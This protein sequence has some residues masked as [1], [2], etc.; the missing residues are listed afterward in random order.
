VD[1]EWEI[2]ACYKSGTLRIG[3]ASLSRI[4]KGAVL[5]VSDED[6]NTLAEPDPRIVRAFS[7]YEL[8]ARWVR[9]SEPLKTSNQ[10]DQFKHLEEKDPYSHKTRNNRVDGGI[11]EIRAALFPE[12]IHNWRRL[13]YGWIFACS[14]KQRKSW[15]ANQRKR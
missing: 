5:E 15:E 10:I 13:N 9:L 4:I 6:G 7:E 14:F 2:D 1:G 8:Y 11:L 12:E 3:A